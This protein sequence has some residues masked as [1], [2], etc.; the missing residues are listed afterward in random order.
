MVQLGVPQ[1]SLVGPLLF[2]TYINDIAS[3]APCNIINYADDTN[4][5]IKAS[6][7]ETLLERSNECVPDVADWF[8]RNRLVLNESKTK[9]VIFRHD[10]STFRAPVSAQ[11]GM[12]TLP[13]LSSVK[14]LG[15]TLDEGLNWK[16]HIEQLA[17]KL[18]RVH[19][20]LRVLKGY[21]SQDSLKIVYLSCFQSILRYGII[22]W[23]QGVGVGDIFVIQKRALRTILGLRVDQSCR[24]HFEFKWPFNNLW[25]VCCGY[26]PLH[27]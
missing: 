20:S 27:V 12:N 17:K 6:T 7:Y 13:F 24:G 5:I 4:L 2:L 18:N 16:L 22:F 3:A 8:M 10:R 1:G 19:Y 14:F 23:G 9:L 11:I 15:L 21:M 26:S 25:F